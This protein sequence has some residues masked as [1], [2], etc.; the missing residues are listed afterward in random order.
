MRRVLGFTRQE[1]GD[2]PWHDSRMY[3]EQVF[4]EYGENA[5][6]EDDPFGESGD[7]PDIMDYIGI[8]GKPNVI[9]VEFGK[10]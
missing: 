7:I 5:T 1:L 9:Q 6:F 10:G 8:A 2:M 3:W 4:A